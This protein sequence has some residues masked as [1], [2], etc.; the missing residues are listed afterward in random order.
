MRNIAIRPHPLLQ[1]ADLQAN[2]LLAVMPQDALGRL[3]PAIEKIR[4]VAGELLDDVGSGSENAY[5]PADMIVTVMVPVDGYKTTKVA[6]IGREGMIGVPYFMGNG[7]PLR[8][9]VVLNN[10][11][12]FKISAAV[13]KTEFD[14]NGPVMRLLL[15]FAQTLI[16]QMAQTAV[17]NRHHMVDQQLCTWLL[18]C[19]DR[20]PQGSPLQVTHE[21]IA[22][23][24][25]VRRESIAESA[26]KLRESGLICYS[27]GKVSLLDRAGMQ[28]KA[29]E[30]YQV[31]KREIDRLLPDRPAT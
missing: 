22:G 27:R 31:V 26:N 17:C 3:L 29:C 13:L 15:R 8:R 28:S 5:F 25:G 6:V 19:I 20:L 10:G 2:G 11:N 30:C 23:M 1:R 16:T 7:L 18:N 24:L 14:R 12:A 4:L 21:T 9:L